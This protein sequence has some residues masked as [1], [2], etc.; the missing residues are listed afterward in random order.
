MKNSVVAIG[1]A[2]VSLTNVCNASN[3]VS[4]KSNYLVEI[5]ISKTE[6]FPESSCR[7]S[8]LLVNECIESVIENRIEK[9]ADQLIAQDNAITENN[10]SNE[11]Q[12]LD[13][14]IINKSDV[15]E[16]IESV[17]VNTLEKSAEQL[18]VEDNAITENNISNDTQA[19]DFTI[20]NRSSTTDEIIETPTSPKI[21]KTADKLIAR[22]NLITENYISNE[23]ITLDFQIINN[24]LISVTANN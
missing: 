3:L 7:N 18:I 19:L 4:M 17:K 1:I 2:L 13:F 5:K 11:I 12:F 9:S 23:I 10:I 22:D 21:E 15:F 14:E 8:N 20:L 6:I 16:G 24:K